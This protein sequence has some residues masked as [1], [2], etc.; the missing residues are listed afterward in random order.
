[1]KNRGWRSIRQRLPSITGFELS[2]KTLGVLGFGNIG[3]KVAIRA[4]TFGMVP[5][6]YDPY[7]STEI[8]ENYGAQKVTFK[9]LL[10][11][12]D[13]VSVHVPL[14]PETKYMIGRKEFKIM[15]KTAN[16]INTSRGQVIDEKA[17]YEALK[18]CWIAGAAVDVL[19]EE[20][21]KNDNPLYSLN[22]ILLTPHIAVYTKETLLRMSIR[23]ARDIVYVLKGQRPLFPVNAKVGDLRS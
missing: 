13:I 9:T 7:I 5:L 18:N 8:I 17:L 11:T 6:V 10:K 4:K 20:P 1:M 16:L 2:Q 21:P 22:N 19:E 14:T 3:R 12:A 23:T 15:K